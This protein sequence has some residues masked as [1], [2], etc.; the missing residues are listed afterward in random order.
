MLISRTLFGFVQP[1]V[2]INMPLRFGSPPP[3]L[4]ECIET[5]A[6]KYVK[7]PSGLAPEIIS[8]YCMW[9]LTSCTRLLIALVIPRA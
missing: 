1:I 7:E 9:C 8:D 2:Y 6:R 4:P 3:P 5:S